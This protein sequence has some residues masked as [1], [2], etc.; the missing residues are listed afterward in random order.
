MKK[1][2]RWCVGLIGL[3][4]L[5]AVSM[6]AD[7]VPAMEPS[8][9][10]SIPDGERRDWPSAQAFCQQLELA[11]L[12]W[13]LPALSELQE[14]YLATKEKRLALSAA[15]PTNTIYDLWIS[16]GDERGHSSLNLRR[17]AVTHHQLAGQRH[18]VT[19]VANLLSTK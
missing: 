18:Y 16:Q 9:L 10:F 17:G 14:L 2:T 5:P 1:G 8:T 13:S 7:S 12:T 6:A 15:W 11:Q 3:L 19:C 4:A